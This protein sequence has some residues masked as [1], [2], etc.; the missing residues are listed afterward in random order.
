MDLKTYWRVLRPHAWIVLLA[1]AAGVLLGSGL[2]AL[3]FE[4]WSADAEVLLRPDDPA[5]RVGEGRRGDVD[6]DRNAAAQEV[7][8]TSRSVL[9][10]VVRSVPDTTVDE[11]R[12]SIQADTDEQAA[13]LT[14]TALADSPRR[15]QVLANATAEAYIETRRL[16]DVVNLQAA[17]GR[18]GEQ[19]DVLER[20]IEELRAD[21]DAA[22]GAAAPADL[23]AANLQYTSLFTQ[24][25]DLLIESTLKRGQAEL[26]NPA[27]LPTSPLGLSRPALAGLGALALGSL[28]I[29]LLLLRDRLDDRVRLAEEVPLLV[30][31]PVLAELPVDPAALRG[32]D[33]LAPH[34]D[35][36][37][38]L[39]EALRT[40]RTAVSFLGLERPVERLLVTS[41]VPGDGKTLVASSLAAAFAQTGVR[42]AVVNA[43]LRRP[44]AEEYFPGADEVAGVTGLLIAARHTESVEELRALVRASL[45]ASPLDPNLWLLPAGAL[46]PNPAEL[47]ASDLFARV[48]DALQSEVDL[49]VIDC[50]PVLP[51]TDAAALARHATHVLLVAG[52]GRTRRAALVRTVEVLRTTPADVL[53]VVLNR[54]SDGGPSDDYRTY[55]Y[56]PAPD[57]VVEQER[58]G[59]AAAVEPAPGRG[60]GARSGA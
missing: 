18:I 16:Q 15:A 25:T 48:L 23:E 9:L 14:I 26:V 27:E 20:R 13:L 45:V 11:L 57:R 31:L 49:V 3:R 46:P 32:S 33:Q 17:A 42:T 43:D 38:R 50:S 24:Q 40:L 56:L 39:A 36:F 4:A 41:A 34:R 47:L 37:G 22:P 21:Q 51:V 8:V 5:E 28:A 35:P 2:H 7:L 58:A 54:T 60:R 44:R 1:L 19:L 12:D 53:G 29:G 6:P 52:A 10:A 30:D 55:G 59:S